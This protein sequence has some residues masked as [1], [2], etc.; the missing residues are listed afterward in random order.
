MHLAL[1]KCALCPL[2][3]EDSACHASALPRVGWSRACSP[4]ERGQCHVEIWEQGKAWGLG[5]QALGIRWGSVTS[6]LCSPSGWMDGGEAT[7]ENKEWGFMGST[8]VLLCPQAPW[9]PGTGRWGALCSA[10]NS[11]WSLP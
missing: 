9:G 5:V 7:H 8:E 1:G 11:L 3:E 4:G 6:P 10:I 2:E